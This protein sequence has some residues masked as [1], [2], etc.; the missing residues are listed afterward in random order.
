M[1]FSRDSSREGAGLN[2]KWWGFATSRVP[3]VVDSS[4]VQRA[5]LHGQRWYFCVRAPRFHTYDRKLLR[6]CAATNMAFTGRNAGGQV[7]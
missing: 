4:V 7:V 5:G 2:K 3:P 6:G 1:L